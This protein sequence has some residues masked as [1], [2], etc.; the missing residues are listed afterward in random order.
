M[1]QVME[2]FPRPIPFHDRV[3][4]RCFHPHPDLTWKDRGEQSPYRC[5]VPRGHGGKHW[6]LIGGVWVEY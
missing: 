4:Q 5:L 6:T 1:G 3:S 2:R